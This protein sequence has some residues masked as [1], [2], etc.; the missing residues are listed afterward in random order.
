MRTVVFDHVDA[1]P[2]ALAE[3]NPPIEWFGWPVP[4]AVQLAVVLAF[5]LAL[6]GFAIVQFEKAE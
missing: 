5:G 2:E 1:S 6:L 4:I 3:L